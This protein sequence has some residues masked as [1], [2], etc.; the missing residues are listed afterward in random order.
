VKGESHFTLLA[1]LPHDTP[2]YRARLEQR[3][4]VPGIGEHCTDARRGK[5]QSC[6]A[7]IWICLEA[8]QAA[9]IEG[10]LAA[11]IVHLCYL[12]AQD[13]AGAPPCNFLAILL[14]NLMRT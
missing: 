6:G 9:V 10:G 2:E 13:T 11:S 14:T 1:C 7:G 12:C 8:R 3:G 4:L 5:C